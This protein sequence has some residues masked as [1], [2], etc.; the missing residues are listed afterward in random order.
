MWY[1]ADMSFEEDFKSAFAQGQSR[2]ETISKLRSEWVESL[3]EGMVLRA[4]RQAKAYLEEAGH[5]AEADKANGTEVYLRSAGHELKF[6]FDDESG[7]IVCTSSVPS[8]DESYDHKRLN[9][10]AVQA[11]IVAFGRALGSL[12]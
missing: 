9:M 2:K 8:L 10:F 3:R 11:K 5:E 12:L 7:K 6:G 1:S 4:F